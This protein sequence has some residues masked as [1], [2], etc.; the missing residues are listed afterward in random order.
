MCRI[1]P[2]FGHNK[3]VRRTTLIIDD[4]RLAEAQRALGTKG[5]KDT[6]DRALDDAIAGDAGRRFVRRLQTMD[7]I[8]LDNP[9]VMDKAWRHDDQPS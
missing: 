6:I 1:R 3:T 2:S 9:D 7:G 5:I 4:S 8:D